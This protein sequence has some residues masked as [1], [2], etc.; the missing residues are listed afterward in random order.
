MVITPSELITE[1]KGINILWDFATLTE[2]KVK[3]NGP[4]IVIKDYKWKT[5]FLIDMTMLED[6]D[7]SVNEY[8]KMINYKDPGIEIEKM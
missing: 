6:S 5:C 7:I 1:A 3:S 4:D 2:R 8:N